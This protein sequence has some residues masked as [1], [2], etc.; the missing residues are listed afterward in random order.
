MI[1]YKVNGGFVFGNYWGGGQGC[2]GLSE[3]ERSND[4]TELL[5]TCEKMLSKGSLDGGQG[6]ESLEGAYIQVDK[7]EELELNDKVF[8]SVETENHIIG[9]IPDDML[10]EL[11]EIMITA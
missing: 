3:V 7:I 8:T 10:D 11:E 4:I 6:F 5:N 1:T 2:Y 9:N